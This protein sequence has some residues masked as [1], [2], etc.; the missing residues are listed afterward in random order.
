MPHL[1]IL[2]IL[3]QYSYRNFVARRLTTALTAGGMGLVVFVFATVL[4]LVHG[5][6]SAL[7]ST[8]SKENVVF[9][10]RSSEVEVQS[11]IPREQAAVLE[12]IREIAVGQDGRELAARELVV[13][14]GLKKRGVDIVSNIL[15][16]G[17]DANLSFQLRPQ[18]R[19]ISGR[20]FQ[21]GSAE[22]VVGKNI[23]RRFDIGG[24]GESIAFGMRSWTVVGIMDGGGSGFDSE[25]WGDA[26]LL[27]A[28]FRRPVYSSVLARL[29][30]PS[31]FEEIKS[32]VLE[33][34]RLTVE[35]FR[36]IDYYASQSELMA[37]FIRILGMTLSLIFSLGAIIGSMVT[38]YAAVAS[39]V[40][41]IGALRALGF[42]RLSILAAFMMES[43]FL[44]LLGGLTG[45]AAASL[46]HRFTLSTMNWQTFSELSFRF[47]LTWD[48]FLKA[49]IFACLMGLVGGT[50]P[51]LRAA[52]M[53][54]V[55][56]LRQR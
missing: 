55:A 49:L 46:M 5:L 26:D 2:F 29:R 22:V 13:L 36:E 39:R 9:I 37:R 47:T 34:P 43:L 21:P 24:L 40:S 35:A 20:R 3:A 56:A 44:G 4:M 33:D 45:V 1:G 31:T 38:M 23:L 11:I 32:R 10:R 27:M 8:G 7:V 30:D 25:V 28:T 6:E 16:R 18:I 50:F 51:A 54:I 14:I 42:N 17:V 48:I 41:E 52:R 19:I 12:N 53:S 15:V